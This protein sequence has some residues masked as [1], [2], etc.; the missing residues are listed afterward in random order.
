MGQL[1][2]LT[3]KLQV[4]FR[5]KC[6]EKFTRVYSDEQINA[7]ETEEEIKNFVYARCPKCNFIEEAYIY[8]KKKTK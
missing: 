1:T 3:Q 6:G 8:T 2:I 5:C 4:R 7:Q